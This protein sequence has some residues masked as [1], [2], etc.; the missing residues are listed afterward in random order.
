MAKCL[1]C[2]D[3][4]VFLIKNQGTLEQEFCDTHL[5]KMYNKLR[6][7]NI[8]ERLDAVATPYEKMREEKEAEVLAVR[9]KT[10]AKKK[11]EAEAAVV[12]EVPAEETPAE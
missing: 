10:K 7:P 4:A 3:N 12:E 9:E 11:A 2:D 6:L 8:V 1:N 5:P